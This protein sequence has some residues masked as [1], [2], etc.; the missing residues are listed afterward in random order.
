MCH[1]AFGD[2]NLNDNVPL[3]VRGS[4]NALPAALPRNGADCHDCGRCTT[5]EGTD[6]ETFGKKIDKSI[7]FAGE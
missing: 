1:Q 6:L 7:T 5:L 3:Y 4:A 2:L